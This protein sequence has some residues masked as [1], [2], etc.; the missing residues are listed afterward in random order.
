MDW[1]VE[2]YH[3]YGKANAYIGALANIGCDSRVGWSVSESCPTRISIAY[4]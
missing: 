3:S 1:Q 4:L 2:I